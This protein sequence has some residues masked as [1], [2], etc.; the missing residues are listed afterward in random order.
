MSDL[1]TD[2]MRE[3]LIKLG[4][5][6]LGTLAIAILTS[7]VNTEKP[8]YGTDTVLA[9]FGED[10]FSLIVF[11]SIW[12]KE[13]L[14]SQVN[15]LL[16]YGAIRTKSLK[17]IMIIFFLLAFLFWIFV[18]SYLVWTLLPQVH[19]KTM[20]VFIGLIK[21]HLWFVGFGLA[22]ACLLALWRGE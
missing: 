21:I 19:A 17:R 14:L 8:P 12:K 6:S 22:Y 11:L 4:I 3:G 18:P 2:R 13:I 20:F 5:G 16:S 7:V 10:I 15:I 1:T 9:F